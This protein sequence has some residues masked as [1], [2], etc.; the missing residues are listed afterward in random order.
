MLQLDNEYPPFELTY[1]SPRHFWV[2]YFPSPQ[3]GCVTW[4]SQYISRCLI[5][6]FNLLVDGVYYG[7]NPFTN[8]LLTFTNFLG[9]PSSFLEGN[10]C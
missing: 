3:I 8:P 9:H 6:G 10:P 1:P 5:N 4:M 2:D 7:F